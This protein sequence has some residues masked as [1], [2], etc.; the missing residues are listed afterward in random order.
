MPL[1]VSCDGCS[2]WS[3]VDCTCPPGIGG[4]FVGCPYV[5][6]DAHL[7]CP[8]G[9]DCCQEDHDHGAMANSCHGDHPDMA[10]PKDAG[11]CK[12]WEN[13]E[14]DGDCPGGHCSVE[15]PDCAVCRP[16]TVTVMPGSVPLTFA[17][18]LAGGA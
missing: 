17:N 7:K 11:R 12:V 8:P 1:H 5:S 18:N 2:T 15:D 16:L 9:S 10:C 6:L 4:H 3:I 13:T 14:G